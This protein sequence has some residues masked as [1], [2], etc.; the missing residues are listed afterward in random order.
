M[1]PRH[2][3]IRNKPDEDLAQS[4]QVR[5]SLLSQLHTMVQAFHGE[6]LELGNIDRD[7]SL[8]IANANLR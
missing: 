2:P 3:A 7:S 8:K 1:Q 6:L 5:W 4:G